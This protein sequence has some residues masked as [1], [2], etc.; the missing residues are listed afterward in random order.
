MVGE[1][2]AI[3]DGRMNPRAFNPADLQRNQTIVEEQCIS[4]IDVFMEGFKRDANT[5][6]IAFRESQG[7][8]QEERIASLQVDT[9]FRETH[10]ANLGSLQVAQQ[11]DIAAAGVSGLAQSAGALP[12]LFGAA[13]G[14]VQTRDVDAASDHL[15]Q[16]FGSL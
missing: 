7:A 13:M 3:D 11:A 2:T 5:L 15:A 16:Y 10:Y 9:A 12:V 1:N 6:L 14:K 8:V 4:L